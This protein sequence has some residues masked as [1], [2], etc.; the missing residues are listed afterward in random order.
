MDRALK[1]IRCRIPQDSYVRLS[2]GSAESLMA[3]KSFVCV[4]VALAQ[5]FYPLHLTIIFSSAGK[6]FQQPG[7]KQFVRLGNL[8]K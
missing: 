4:A 2:A 7:F 5:G 3:M 8:G 1:L 6:K